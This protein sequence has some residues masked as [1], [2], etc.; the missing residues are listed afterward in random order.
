M[1]NGVLTLSPLQ[2]FL[3]VLALALAVVVPVFIAGADGLRRLADLGP[4]EAA[5]LLL[6][7]VAI[8]HLNLFRLRLLL[9]RKPASLTYWRMIRVYMSIEFVSKATPAGSGAPLAAAYYLR[10]YGISAHKALAL[11]LV[12][13]IMDAL[14]LLAYLAVLVAAV[15]HDSH[16]MGLVTAGLIA[17][18]PLALLFMWLSYRHYRLLLLW[19]G[20]F[21]RAMHVPA[22]LQRKLARFVLRLRQALFS[23]ASIPA[24][25]MLVSVLLCT[26]MWLLY[27]SVIFTVVWVLGDALRWPVA[28][29][30]QVAAMGLGHL[31]MMPG[32]AGG[33]EAVSAALLV[34]LLGPALTASVVICWRAMMLHLY[35]LVGG[36]AAVSLSRM[37]APS[38]GESTHRGRQ[39]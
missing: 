3:L 9:D 26:V 32:A 17:A 6:L 16:M 19:M 28:A 36:L 8:W 12:A 22:G 11:F 37:S 35:L 2:R 18:I 23:V 10:P 34:P 14:V 15:E 4:S 1:L 13:A 39:Q 33:A 20:R 7:M 25:K 24:W 5:L 31:M 27:L 30:I 21:G 29:S 38:A